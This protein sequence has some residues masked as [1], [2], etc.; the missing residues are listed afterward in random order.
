MI[1]RSRTA[2][3]RTPASNTRNVAK[4]LSGDADVVTSEHEE[5]TSMNEDLRSMKESVAILTTAAGGL[6]KKVKENLKLKWSFCQ[7]KINN[8]PQLQLIG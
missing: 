4:T 8:F 1:R 3:T 6:E 5:S 2:N 7:L